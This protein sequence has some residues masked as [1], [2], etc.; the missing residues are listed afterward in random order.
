MLETKNVFSINGFIVEF[1][2][3]NATM[4][5]KPYF[6]NHVRYFVQNRG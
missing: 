3:E 1:M 4:S 6:E 2:E 5:S